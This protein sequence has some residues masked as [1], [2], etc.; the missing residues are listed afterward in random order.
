MTA[1]VVMVAAVVVV[2]VLVVTVIVTVLVVIKALLWAGVVVKTSVEVLAIGAC[3]DM[4]V[5]TRSG[6]VVINAVD[7]E[8]IA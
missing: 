6:V 3:A 2:P 7:V 5:G 4:V 1:L 8:V